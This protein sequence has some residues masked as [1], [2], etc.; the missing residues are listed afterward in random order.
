M[1]DDL[2]GC[3]KS[4]DEVGYPVVVKPD[5]GVGASDTHKLSSD[6]ELKRFLLYKSTYHPD[7]IMEEFVHA[8]VNSY[9]AII[10][11]SGNPILRRATSARCPLWTSSTTP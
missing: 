5:N 6:E 2:E 9:D 11:G 3:R 1:V 7:H 8:E 10:D 4:I